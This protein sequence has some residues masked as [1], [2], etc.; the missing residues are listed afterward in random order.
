MPIDLVGGPQAGAG[1]TKVFGC[2][3]KCRGKTIYREALEEW[4][5]CRFRSARSTWPA[6][7]DLLKNKGDKVRLINIGR[8]VWTVYAGVPDFITSTSCIAGVT[9][10]Y[11][12]QRRQAASKEKAL[13]F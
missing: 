7:Q 9:L 10:I 2:S 6:V 4:A 1:T 13:K 3:M 5:P 12:H 11:F 8:P